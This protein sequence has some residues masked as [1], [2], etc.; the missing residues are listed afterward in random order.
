[1][2]VASI[3]QTKYA[4]SIGLGPQPVRWFSYSTGGQNLILSKRF[5]SNQ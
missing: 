5:W 2:K 4:Y 3:F 1:L